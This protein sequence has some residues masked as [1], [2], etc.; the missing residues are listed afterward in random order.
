MGIFLD[1]T[2]I[3]A[4]ISTV[5]VVPIT[6]T[7]FLFNTREDDN[8]TKLIAHTQDHDSAWKDFLS[9][10]FNTQTNSKPQSTED[11]QTTESS[12]I[13]NSLQPTGND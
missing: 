13:N 1:Y 10:R 2:S 7:R 4:F 3:V 8:I 11:E 5:I 9:D 6:I 12:A